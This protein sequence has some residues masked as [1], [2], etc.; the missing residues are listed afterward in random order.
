MLRTMCSFPLSLS[1]APPPPP[2]FSVPISAY[3]LVDPASGLLLT[4]VLIC[5]AMVHRIKKVEATLPVEYLQR[6]GY[7]QVR[8]A[9]TRKIQQGWMN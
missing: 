6:V 5:C 4:N 9:V 2:S 7:L 3:P 1:A 8:K